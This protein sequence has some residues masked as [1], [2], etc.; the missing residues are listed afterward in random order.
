M[1]DRLVCS[2]AYLVAV[3]WWG[4]RNQWWQV[5]IRVRGVDVHM[6]VRVEN[7][8]TV[9]RGSVQDGQVVEVIRGRGRNQCR[10]VIILVIV[11]IF[12]AYGVAVDVGRGSVHAGQVEIHWLHMQRR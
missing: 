3:G 12:V 7:R 1:M 8:N 9:G 6:V 10:Q 11:L 4:C 5:N 2:P